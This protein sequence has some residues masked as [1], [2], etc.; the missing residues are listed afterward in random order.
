MSRDCSCA[1][2]HTPKPF[3]MYDR[4]NFQYFNDACSFPLFLDSQIYVGTFFEILA[5]SVQIAEMN[6]SARIRSQIRR[7]PLLAQKPIYP[8]GK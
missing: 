4:N 7:K 2:D 8:F 1:F 6:T 3:S 5:R